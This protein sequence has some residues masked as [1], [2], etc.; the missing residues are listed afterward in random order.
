VKY[1]PIFKVEH[2]VKQGGAV[3]VC[4]DS[5][6]IHKLLHHDEIQIKDISEVQFITAQAGGGIGKLILLSLDGRGSLHEI[7]FDVEHESDAEKLKCEIEEKVKLEKFEKQFIADPDTMIANSQAYSTNGPMDSGES[8]ASGI[9]PD[10]SG[11]DELKKW[12]ELRDKGILTPEEFEFKKKELLYSIRD[13]DGKEIVK[14]PCSY[15]GTL[16]NVSET[17]CPNCGAPIQS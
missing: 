6:V 15:C 3:E 2:L 10:V 12:A 1:E 4:Y 5:I 9:S 11:V 14:I 8:R 17:K 7:L 13:K 16:I